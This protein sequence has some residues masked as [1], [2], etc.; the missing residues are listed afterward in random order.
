M[1]G[2]RVMGERVVTCLRAGH[3]QA[4]TL[5]VKEGCLPSRGRGWRSQLV[6]L[7]TCQDGALSSTGQGVWGGGENLQRAKWIMSE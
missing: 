1:P 6:K 7:E 4:V 3:G 5:S 2:A